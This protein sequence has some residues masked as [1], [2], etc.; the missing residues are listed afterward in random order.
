M[1][2][3]AGP[4][5]FG[6]TQAFVKVIRTIPVDSK[7]IIFDLSQVYYLDHSGIY[8]LEESLQH[9]VDSHEVYIVGLNVPLQRRL[10]KMKIIPQLIQPDHVV[11]SF[12]QLDIEQHTPFSKKRSKN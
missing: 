10:E 12:E 8:T 3:T 1:F 11:E 6:N 4:L 5:F 7:H 9:L 2:I